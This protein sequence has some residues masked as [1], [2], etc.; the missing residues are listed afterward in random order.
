MSGIVFAG[1]SPHPPILIPEIGNENLQEI[2]DTREGM[3]RFA[4][5]VKDSN[6]DLVITISPHGPVFSDAISI[7][8]T[9]ELKG[10][11]GQFGFPELELNYEL[12][13]EMVE[14]IVKVTK[15]E[16][17]T[18]ARIDK[19]TARKF[20]INPK[21]DHGALVPLYYLA[22]A[23]VEDIPIIPI[24]MGMLPYEELYKFGKIIQLIAMKLEYRVAIIASGDL[25]HRLT[26][27]APAG[28]NS[29]AKEFDKKL[30]QALK[31]DKI[32][33]IFNLDQQL[34]EKAG[35]CGL[36][37]II[38]MLGAIDGLDVSNELLSYEGPFGVGYGVLTYE[39]EGEDEDRRQLDQLLA[40]RNAKLKQVREEE[41]KLVKLARKAVE[42]YALNR[43][44]ILPPEDLT[45]QMQKEAGVFVSIKKHGQLR[46]CIGTTEP[47]QENIAKEIIRNSLSAGFNDPRFEEVN[48][49][50]LDDLIYTVDILEEPESIDSLDEL[51]PQKFG[52]I[53]DKGQNSGLLLPRLEGVDTV[54][55][56][57]EIAKR[58]AG[59]SPTEDDIELKRFKVTRYK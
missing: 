23:D 8:N 17:I 30:V 24:T 45:P 6:P 28:Y 25:S 26:P 33:D 3:K 57:V 7:M 12:Q 54:E 35:E 39:I 29:Q 21:L 46:G 5:R 9:Q 4:K 55:K 44:K 47:V 56:Q 51:D 41:S 20:E 52:V 49:N 16:D 22:E 34:I 58:K 36:R 19:S 1:L 59:L 48:L 40:D 14:E 11:F 2:E 50:E 27:D 13:E 42:K 38:I 10:D 37:P 18:V 15:Q 53:V 32:E 43:E 31:E